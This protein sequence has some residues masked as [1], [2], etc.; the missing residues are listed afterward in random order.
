MLYVPTRTLQ[1]ALDADGNGGVWQSTGLPRRPEVLV[2]ALPPLDLMAAAGVVGAI[3]LDLRTD[4][5]DRWE[6]PQS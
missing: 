3:D 4:L 1:T 2:A 5:L 6:V